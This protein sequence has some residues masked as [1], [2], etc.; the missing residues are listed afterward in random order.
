[1]ITEGSLGITEYISVMAHF[2]GSEYSKSG[3]SNPSSEESKC[4][5]GDGSQIYCQTAGSLWRRGTCNLPYK[6]FRVEGMV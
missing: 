4:L 2:L 6:I 5:S 1:M 3:Y